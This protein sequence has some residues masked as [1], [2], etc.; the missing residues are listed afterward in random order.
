M[1]NINLDS[2]NKTREQILR[3]EFP[4]K[5]SFEVQGEWIFSFEGQFK[6]EIEFPNG[7]LNLITDQPPP[8]GGRGN[9]PNPVQYCVFAMISCYATTFMTIAASKGVEIKKLK[10]RGASIVNM[11]SVFEIEEGPVVE[12]VWIELE[13]ESEADAKILQEIKNEADKKCPAAYVVQN[14]VPFESHVSSK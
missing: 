5:K 2:L 9:A 11:K 10:A 7:K 4:D 13:V 14:K 8:S 6:S 3:G 12:K 1:N